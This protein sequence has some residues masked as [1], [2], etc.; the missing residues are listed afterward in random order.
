MN[1]RK[2]IALEFDAE[3][4]AAVAIALTKAAQSYDKA[5]DEESARPRGPNEQPIPQV[6]VWRKYAKALHELAAKAATAKG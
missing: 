1:K 3:L 6:A 4:G 2:R 5:A